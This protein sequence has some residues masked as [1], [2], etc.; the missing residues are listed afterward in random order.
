MFDIKT[1][2]VEETSTLELLNGKDEPIIGEGGK[3]ASIT[4]YGPGTKQYAAAQ[5]KQ[6]ARA[7]EKLRKKGKIEPTAEQSR[8]ETAEFLASCTVSFNNFGDADYPT[9]GP[10]MFKAVYAN[11]SIGFIAEQVNKHISDWANFTRS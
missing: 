4:V 7:I 11:P 6:S 10:E 8:A 1:L 9:G 3:P 5:A 2:A